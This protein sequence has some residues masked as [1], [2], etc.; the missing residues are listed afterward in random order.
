[1]TTSSVPIELALANRVSTDR[2]VVSVRATTYIRTMLDRYVT[3]DLSSYP[4]HW[5]YMPADDT[6]MREWHKAMAT[7][8]PASKE[9]TKRYQELFGSLLHAVKYRPEIS[10]AMGRLGSC[11]TFATEELYECMFRVLIYLG[12]TLKLGVTYSAHVENAGKLLCFA[13]SDWDTTRST[14]G[15]V[16]MLAGAA[17]ASASRR[18]HC[19]SMSSTEAELYALAEA[20][21]ELLFIKELVQFVGHKIDG[22]I[23]VA[24]DNKGAYDLCH[25]FSSAQHSRHIDRKM[26]KM[27]E[28]RGND[29]VEVRH[30]PTEF[31]PADIFT[32]ILSRQPFERHRK[33]IL[34]LH[35]DTG[36][37][38]AQRTRMAAKK[39]DASSERDRTGKG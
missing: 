17:I 19:I 12:S 10:T 21:I 1:M 27:R 18:Q 5:K 29:I 20:A 33:T 26:F 15:F 6:L 38:F 32:K 39:V 35:G 3:R 14:T 16:I 8:T 30:V 2:N 36:V 37:E 9:L 22:P 4:A 31:N 24:T 23:D 7:R 25:R 34:N 28:L 13:D 11:L